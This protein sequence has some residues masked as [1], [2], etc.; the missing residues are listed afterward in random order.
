MFQKKS[1]QGD[2]PA[3]KEKKKELCELKCSKSTARK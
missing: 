2:P 3:R 1:M